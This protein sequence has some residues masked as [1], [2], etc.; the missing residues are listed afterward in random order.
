MPANNPASAFPGYYGSDQITYKANVNKG[1]VNN[2]GAVLGVSAAS[3][4]NSRIFDTDFGYP[5]LGIHNGY[6]DNKPQLIPSNTVNGVAKAINAGTFATMVAGKYIMVGF[7]SQIAGIA[8]TLLNSP[9]MSYN[10][11]SQDISNPYR[12]SWL[13]RTTGGWYY[14]TGQ[15]VNAQ[16][17]RD[18]FK[19]DTN[20]GTYA[21]PGRLTYMQG[22]PT[23][24]VTQYQAKT[25]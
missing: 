15:P 23:A 21:H 7:T 25:D 24:L 19:T 2:G 5:Y 18:L 17:S 9:G 11:K 22:A 3:R 20:T 6:N 16:S 10:V 14:Q 12:N 4:Q 1:T 13:K 8:N